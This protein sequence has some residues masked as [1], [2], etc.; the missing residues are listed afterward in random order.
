MLGNGYYWATPVNA[1]LMGN[2][3]RQIVYVRNNIVHIFS[4]DEYMLIGDF[5]DYMP[6]VSED[7]A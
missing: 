6:V 7:S 3:D 5:T 4:D 2:T 1:L